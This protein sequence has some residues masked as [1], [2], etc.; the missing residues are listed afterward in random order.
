MAAPDYDTRLVE[1]LCGVTESAAQHRAS[2]NEHFKAGRFGDAA[3]AYSDAISLARQKLESVMSS[4]DAQAAA[5]RDN[6]HGALGPALSALQHMLAVCLVNRATC[7]IR[8]AHFIAALDDTW[9]AI[10]VCFVP[11]SHG[12]P[13]WKRTLHTG[14]AWEWSR[15]AYLKAVLRRVEAADAAGVPMVAYPHVA[16]AYESMPRSGLDAQAQ[17]LRQQLASYEVRLHSMLTLAPRADAESDCV[18]PAAWSKLRI[19]AAGAPCARFGAATAAVGNVLL[20]FGGQRSAAGTGGE[21]GDAWRL[22]L[23]SLLSNASSAQL[24]WERL[25][26]PARHGGPRAGRAPCGAGCESLARFVVLCQRGVLWTLPAGGDGAG[27]ARLGCLWSASQQAVAFAGDDPDPFALSLVVCGESALVYHVRGGLIR[28]CLR[29]GVVTAVPRRRSS[30]M[31]EQRRPQV[32]PEAGSGDGSEGAP[33]LRLRVWGGDEPDVQ[34]PPGS[35][36]LLDD[37]WHFEGRTW[38]IV[39]RGGGGGAVPPQRTEASFAPLPGG[40]AVLLGGFTDR[41]GVMPDLT[42][43]R[44]EP[45]GNMRIQIQGSR[46]LNDAYLFDETHGWRALRCSGK[47]P[48]P[49]ASGSLVFHA[50]SKALLAFGGW[51]DGARPGDSAYFSPADVFVLRIDALADEADAAGDADDAA[52]DVSGAARC[53]AQCGRTAAAAAAAGGKLQQCARCHAARY[54]SADCQRAA[55]PQHRASCARR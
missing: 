14:S 6:D 31:F 53:C 27:W 45:G 21:L 9:E 22:P 8:Q 42:T 15:G 34:E 51:G 39:K 11:A 20:L 26:E 33:R 44:P 36:P 46:L 2:G 50:A 43:L 10:D 35:P 49:A 4:A 13:S 55:W 5:A 19:K 3:A 32:W 24:A 37:M 7:A 52:A 47:P 41:M 1:M 23:K 28:V 30:A 54:C 38:H 40:R 48:P 16:W 25:P 17:A 12:E 18:L 29:T